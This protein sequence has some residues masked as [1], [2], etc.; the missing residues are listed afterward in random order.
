MN[1]IREYKRSST[2]FNENDFVVIDKD[3]DKVPGINPKTLYPIGC[4]YSL[5]D[6]M[7]CAMCEIEDYND[8]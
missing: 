2:S 4:P 7:D 5:Q 8:K 6:I 1:D 3:K